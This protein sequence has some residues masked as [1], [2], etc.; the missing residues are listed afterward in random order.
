MGFYFQNYN[1]ITGWNLDISYNI[2][3]DSS[4]SLGSILASGVGQNLVAV[5]SGLPWCCGGGNAYLVTFNL[6]SPFNATGGTT[7]WLE[8]TGASGSAPDA[9]W[10]TANAN[11]THTGYS[12]FGGGYQDVGQQF[13]FF[14]T[15]TPFASGVPEPSSYALVLGGLSFLGCMAVRRRTL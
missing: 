7:Y 12:N 11:S 3:A 6:Q 14:L 1:G 9:W 13:A 8:L 2:R 15:D 10:V 4:G 5:D